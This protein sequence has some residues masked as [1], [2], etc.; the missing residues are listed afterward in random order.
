MASA[1]ASAALLSR[2]APAQGAAASGL[3]ARLEGTI[4]A[5]HARPAT[6]K[7]A[8][9]LAALVREGRLPPVAQRVP[10]EPVVLRPVR[11]I[12]RNGGTWCRGVTGP[13]DVENGNR[14]NASGKLLFRDAT[15]AQIVPSAA[16]GVEMTQDDTLYTIHPR[17]GASPV[18]ARRRTPSG[19]V[20]ACRYS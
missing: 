6:P 12:G 3:V 15:G 18:G 16:K 8:P 19:R 1:A 17:L 20:G 14:V 13:G 7:E 4:I 11:A 9:R 5:G 2:G 10:A